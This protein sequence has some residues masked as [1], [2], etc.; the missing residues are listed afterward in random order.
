[1]TIECCLIA[2]GLRLQACDRSVVIVAHIAENGRL[3][4]P[5]ARARAENIRAAWIHRYSPERI[6]NSVHPRATVAANVT[7][8]FNDCQGF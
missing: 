7:C 4:S 8:V 6:I 5:R 2:V 1:M 3:P